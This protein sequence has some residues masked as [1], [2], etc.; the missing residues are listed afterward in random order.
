MELCS[1]L[2]SV[3]LKC[4]H[5]FTCLP[6]QKGFANFSTL[7]SHIFKQNQKQEL[8]VKKY[9]INSKM[10]SLL[11]KKGQQH[12]PH[13]IAKAT[14][15]ADSAVKQGVANHK[16]FLAHLKASSNVQTRI[17]DTTAQHPSTR[18]IEG[19]TKVVTI[20]FVVLPIQDRE[21]MLP[22]EL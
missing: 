9:H 15:Y 11:K 20:P 17:L 1:S 3:R 4:Q 19:K 18:Y 5:S 21:V 6:S 2:R 22:W 14:L 7:L 16:V 10:F 8:V 13:V 12:D